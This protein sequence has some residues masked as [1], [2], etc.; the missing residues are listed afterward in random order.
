MARSAKQDAI[1]KFRFRVTVLDLDLSLVYEL[2]EKGY[3]EGGFSQVTLPRVTITETSYREN[4]DS[5]RKI[6]VPG[7]SS[8]E[9]VVLKRGV[10]EN[11]DFY[12]WLKTVNNDAQGQSPVNSLI[13]S[14]GYLPVY[15][16]N[17][18]K[19]VIIRT[20]NRAGQTVKVWYL[21]N[22]WPSSFKGGDDLLATA[23]EKLLEEI[24]LT[25]ES[26]IELSNDDMATLVE[27][28]KDADKKSA[29]AAIA[30]FVLTGGYKNFLG[31]N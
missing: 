11:R 1:E 14:Q 22:A 20:F 9:P 5:A 10:G 26:F 17:F 6:K 25:Y 24:T 4:I 2:S 30:A 13:G 29:A 28:I 16:V 18:R 8:Y 15:P 3:F 31:N 21:F 27:E 12:N 23:D 7:L 19:D